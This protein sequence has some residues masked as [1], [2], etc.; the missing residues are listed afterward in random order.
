MNPIFYHL[1]KKSSVL[2][3][4]QSHGG[5]PSIGL[6]KNLYD[7]FFGY[8]LLRDA[9]KVIALTRVEAEQ[10]K[11]IGDMRRRSPL[12]PTGYRINVNYLE[13]TLVR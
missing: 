10:Y 8:R 3:V 7:L 2:Y 12:Y 9:S 5:L 13:L 6:S 11:R 4:I 1:L